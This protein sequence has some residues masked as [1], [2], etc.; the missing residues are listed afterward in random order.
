M[1]KRGRERER[2]SHK[3]GGESVK[4]RGREIVKELEGRGRDRVMGVET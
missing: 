1:D 2:G 3:N 4:E